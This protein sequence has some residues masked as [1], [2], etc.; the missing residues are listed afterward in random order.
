M[1]GGEDVQAKAIG[2]DTIDIAWRD[3]L[4]IA[5]PVK[6]A[7]NVVT[8]LQISPSPERTINTGQAVTYE[9]SALRGG[10]RVILTHE[11]GVLLSVTDPTVASVVS[12]NTVQGS[13]PGRTKVIADYGGQKAETILNVTPGVAGVTTIGGTDIVR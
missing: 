2:E 11:D 7:A 4:K 1:I 13:G 12:G 10:N 9:V 5:V 3:K 8:D 6:V